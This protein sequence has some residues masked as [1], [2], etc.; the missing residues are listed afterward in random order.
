MS[1]GRG[2]GNR[3]A[4]APAAGAAPGRP[5]GHGGGF[6]HGPMGGFGAPVQKAKNFKGSLKRLLGY[7]RPRMASLVSVFVLAIA[8]TLFA[9]FAPKIMGHATTKIYDGLMG[10]IKHQAG[11]GV[12]FGSIGQ[13]VV[14]LI[15][16]YAVSAIF[17]YLQQ[18]IM[19]GVAQKTA[20][21]MRKDVSNK[22]ARLPLKFFDGR[23]HGEII[24]P[25]HQ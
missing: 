13:I 25:G 2:N 10:M 17:S 6:G 20:Y 14:I 19:A 16:L 9:V 12:D 21:D 5:A 7:L 15:G 8:S 4:G 24:E 23:T 22:L 3:P 11:A 18:F 1:D